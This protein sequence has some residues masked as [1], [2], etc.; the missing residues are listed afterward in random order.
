MIR[1]RRTVIGPLWILATPIMFIGF[2]GT[3]FVGLSN[4]S[5]SVFI[6]HMTIG[7]I[8]WTLLGG[9]LSRSA[10]LYSR[11]KSIMLSGKNRHTDV[12]LLDMSEL[13]VHFLH[14]AILIVAV[15][16]FYGTIKSHYSLF[17]LL[18]FLVVIINGV[19]FTTVVAIVGARL[20]DLSQLMGSVS[21]ILFLATPI[22]WM[23]SSAPGE[24]LSRRGNILETYMN[25]NPFY[26]FLQIIRAPLMNDPVEPLTLWVVGG[27]TLFGFTVVTFI[28][29][30]YRHMVVLWS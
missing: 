5:T 11:N 29:A 15:C 17:S 3:L 22:I 9:Y 21:S 2:L 13:V 16:L 10:T 4:F 7:F 18:G 25:Y 28:Y 30:K 19:W 23:P 27:V 1:Y 20:P 6:P 14:Q 24:A 8:C 26:H 12:I